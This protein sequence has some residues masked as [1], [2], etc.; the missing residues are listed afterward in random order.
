M[1]NNQ[2]FDRHH[3][4]PWQEG[5]HPGEVEYLRVVFVGAYEVRPAEPASMLSGRSSPRDVTKRPQA[6]LPYGYPGARQG[7]DG[8][9]YG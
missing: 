5:P 7:V 9:W 8:R 2:A 6:G 4:F 1:L 3:R